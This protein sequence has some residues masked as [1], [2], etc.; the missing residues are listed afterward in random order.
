MQADELRRAL[1]KGDRVELTRLEFQRPVGAPGREPGQVQTAEEIYDR[2]KVRTSDVMRG[3]KPLG[4]Y[5][6]RDARFV[7]LRN[8]ESGN[9]HEF[10]MGVVLMLRRLTQAERD[11]ELEEQTKPEP[12]KSALATAKRPAA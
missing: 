4:L 5:V 1:D 2:G 10:P 11:R 3:R 9:E 8:L 12:P 7:F 6:D